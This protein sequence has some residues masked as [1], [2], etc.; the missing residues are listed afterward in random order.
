MDSLFGIP[1]NSIMLVLVVLLIVCLAAVAYVA[2]RS[3]IMFRIGLRNIPR[4]VAQTVL[5]IIGLMLSTIIIS[6]AF[7]T[8]DT[9]DYSISNEAFRLLGH[10][11]ETVQAESQREDGGRL[12]NTTERDIPGELR[13]QFQ[14]AIAA[15][16]NPD[17]DGSLPVL[18]EEVPVINLRGRQSE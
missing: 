17:I 16:D 4:R 18:L 5:I 12:T 9:V 2:L 13:D 1:M 14:T 15:A 10:I 7:T 3:R 6:A 8:G 11:D